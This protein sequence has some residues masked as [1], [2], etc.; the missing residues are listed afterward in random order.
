MLYGGKHEDNLNILR[1]RKCCEK[2]AVKTTQLQ[3]E[4]LPPT[5]PAAKYHSFRAYLQIQQWKG[6]NTIRPIDWGWQMS[7][8]HLLP[9]LT[10]QQAAP[11]GLLR[12][13]HCGC[14]GNCSNV[15]CTCRKNNMECSS[16]CTQ[17]RGTSCSNCTV[18][19]SESDDD[20][21]DV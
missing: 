7:G 12:V 5:S 6:S 18:V 21:D 4:V 1:Y 20:V 9:V 14:N 11:G 17:C 16:A 8:V 2:T 19:E 3:S 10:D 15:R 13:V